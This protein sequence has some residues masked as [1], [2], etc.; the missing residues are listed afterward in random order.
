MDDFTVL[1]MALEPSFLQGAEVMRESSEIFKDV[2]SQAPGSLAYWGHETDWDKPLVPPGP[3]WDSREYLYFEECPSLLCG[4]SANHQHLKGQWK[5]ENC[6]FVFPWWA[7]GLCWLVIICSG[8]LVPS[9]Q[10]GFGSAS[11]M[12]EDEIQ[13]GLCFSVVFTELRSV[14]V[15]L[16]SFR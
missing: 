6:S 13:M 2:Q 8:S 16:G 9:P 4:V 10:P 14:A 1:Y 15:L 11:V 5:L 7:L 12:G 3:C